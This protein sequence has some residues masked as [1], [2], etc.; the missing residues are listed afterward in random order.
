MTNNS[1]LKDTLSEKRDKK[2]NSSDSQIL[3]QGLKTINDLDLKQLQEKYR[4]ELFNLFIPNMDK[5]VIDHEFGG[6]MCSVDILSCELASTE[7]VTWF[8]GRGIWLYSFLYNNMEKDARYLEIAGKSKDFILNNLPKDGSFYPARFSREGKPLENS[9]G[10]IYGNLFVAEGLAEYSKATGERQ[11]FQQAKSIISQAV[12]R[13]DDPGFFYPYKAEKRVKGPR[14]LGVWMI[15]LSVASQILRQE[16]DQD[17]KKLADRC[18]E[19]IMKYHMNPEYNLL[20]EALDHNLNTLTDK[21]ASQFADIGHGCETLAFVMNYA[22]LIKDKKLLKAAAKAFKRHVTVAKDNIYG[23][24]F[25]ELENVKEN[26]WNL[27]KVRWLQEEILIGALILIEHSG[28]EWALNCFAETDAY[29]R[30]KFMRPEYAFTIDRGDRKLENYS[31]IR[32][33]Q[34]H[35]PRQ[36]M[37]SLLAIERMIKRKGKTSGLF[38]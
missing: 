4:N 29:V 34:Y 38:V 24:Y 7:K 13:Y 18:V 11:Y 14:I 17:M 10:D 8:E 15:L 31:R 22:V 5:Y 25:D 20:N 2:G 28:D 1:T 12:E 3:Q 23:G 27:R 6:F 21:V 32:A 9:E 35:Y 30:E 19:A 26:K 16:H 37:M 36:L 33:E